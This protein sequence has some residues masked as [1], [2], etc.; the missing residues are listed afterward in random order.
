LKDVLDAA[1]ARCE[2]LAREKQTQ[3]RASC[4]E[5]LSA[6]IQ[7]GLIEQA[8]V[9]L[10]DNAIKYS[11]PGKT[12]RIEARRLPKETVIAVADEGFGID[13]KHL[14]RLFER[15]YRVDRG[16]SREVGGTGLGL[17][18]VKHIALAHGGWVSVESRPGEGSTFTLHLPLP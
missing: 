8:L 4:P 10:V 11:P 7:P 13:A 3:L 6:R 2:P 12:V 17:A 18:I 9:N 16:R 5:D 14:P 1:V 15:F